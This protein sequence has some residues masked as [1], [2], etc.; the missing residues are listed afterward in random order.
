MTT[1]GRFG[2][3][4]SVAYFTLGL[5][6]AALGQAVENAIKFDVSP[7]L[8]SIQPP[9][10]P[11]GAFLR[12]HIVKKIPL[13]PEKLAALADTAL[14]KKATTKLPVV[15][16]KSFAG[17]GRENYG[18]MSDPPPTPVSP[19]MTPTMKPDSVWARSIMCPL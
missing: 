9:A 18:V 13:P 12:E 1:I 8:R 11:Q 19:T 7:P 10:R 15:A 6:P 16:G 14:Q 3:V 4:A 2:A 17:V 5:A